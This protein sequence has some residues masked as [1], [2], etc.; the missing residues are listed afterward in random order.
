M[1]PPS[2]SEAVTMTAPGDRLTLPISWRWLA[3]VPAALVTVLLIAAAVDDRRRDAQLAAVVARDCAVVASDS[4]A[5]DLEALI[6][7][8]ASGLERARLLAQCVQALFPRGRSVEILFERDGRV[9][10]VSAR[11]GPAAWDDDALRRAAGDWSDMVAGERC[12]GYRLESGDDRAFAV[13]LA[14]QVGDAPVV[15]VSRQRMAS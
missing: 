2:P 7:E 12:R 14:V 10:T 15:I 5:R 1:S 11:H 6:A 4:L 9:R 8:P 13:L 3:A